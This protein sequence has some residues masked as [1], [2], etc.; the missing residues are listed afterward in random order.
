MYL[1][2]HKPK[3]IVDTDGMPNDEWLKWRTTGIGGSDVAAIYGISPWTTKRALYYS[4]IGLIKDNPPNPYTLDFGHCVEPFVA[5]WFQQAFETKYKSWLERNLGK[6][7]KSFNIYKD[8]FMYQHP[9]HPF[10]QANL[11]Y[12][13]VVTTLDDETIQGIFECKTTSYHIGFDKWKDNICPSYYE[14]QCRHYMAIMNVPYT[15]I[16]CAWGN[17]ENDYGVA[18]VERDEK[19]EKE[20]IA[21]EEDFWVNNVQKRNPPPLNS[22]KGEQE[23]EA[24]N[25][26]K[27]SKN[28]KNGTLK[29]INYASSEVIDAC[30]EIVDLKE[31]ERE[32]KAEI[33]GLESKIN[34][35]K[36]ALLEVLDKNNTTEIRVNDMF[37]V[38]NKVTISN[39]FNTAKFQE[40]HPEVYKKYL[41]ESTSSR[42]TVTPL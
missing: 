3:C 42:F 6:K 7:I 13:F 37:T 25:S 9:D 38:R 23:L 33:D 14:T 28:I 32:L 11:D 19:T 35:K 17:N 1:T 18:F 41:K 8:T 24:Y 39:R 30:M 29:E 31:Q 20:L 2:K 5:T 16:A 36:V 34:A 12:R 40:E 22:N 15:I 21:A 26:Y 27:V 4:K 10:M